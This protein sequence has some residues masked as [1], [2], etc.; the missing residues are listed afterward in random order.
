MPALADLTDWMDENAKPHITW[1]VKRLSGNDTL[2]NGSNQAGPYIPK[3][4]LFQ[5]FPSLHRPADENPDKWFEARIDSH[6]DVRTVRAVWYNSAVREKP[7]AGEKK[8]KSRNEARITNFGGTESALLDPESTG[9]V[10]VFAFH[11]GESGEADVCHIWVCDHETEAELVED[12]VGPVEPGKLSVWTVNEREKSLLALPNRRSSC[13]L[14]EHEIPPAW[15]KTFPT[16]AEIIRKTVELR[17]EQA[18]TIDKRLM[19]RREC[20]FELFRSLENAVEM[21]G[22]TKGFKSV[23]EF[24]V[25]AQRITQRRKSRSGKSLELHARAIFLEEELEE[26]SHFDYQPETEAGRF[27]DFLFPS[28]AAYKDVTFPESRLRMLAAKTT[29]KD[30][31]P[32]VLKEADRIRTKH[33]LTLQEGVSRKQFQAMVEAG[34][35]LVVPVPLVEAYH[36]DIRP[37]LQSLESFVADVRL[38]AIS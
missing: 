22:I 25:R 12:R 15:L 7:V 19:K 9:S 6:A 30:R 27:P 23:D 11:R 32:Q 29:F 38:L 18:L 28:K 20:E 3:E 16:G 34:V 31:W 21:P 14:E 33:L 26:G 2:A 17:S 10:A 5:V 35:Q 8:K 24:L 37:H 13:W 36:K 1:Y 4:F